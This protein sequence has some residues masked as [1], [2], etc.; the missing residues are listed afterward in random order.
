MKR[1]R[2]RD[3]V[4]LPWLV[5]PCLL[6]AGLLAWQ[7]FVT[8][9]NV[10]PFILPPPRPVLAEWVLLLSSARAWSHTAMTFAGA[11]SGFL[12]A[13]VLGVAAGILLS[14]SPTLERL[15]KPFIVAF[16]V[17]PKVALIPLFVVWMGFGLG[18]KILT[19]AILPFYPIMMNTL[20]GIRSVPEGLRDVMASF[21]AGRFQVL[22]RLELPYALPF[23]A[24]GLEVGI[25]LA[26]VGA[27][28]AEFI[29]G[30]SG[31]GYLLVSRIN[32][33]E[34]AQMFAIVLQ[35]CLLGL[36]LYAGVAGLRRLLVPRRA[37]PRPE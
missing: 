25:V 8:I 28:V 21:D 29:S 12:L 6:A 15:S 32:S 5:T 27:V 17:L 35:L 10:S 30:S 23:I 34:T 1:V 4:W 37:P 16:Q 3:A 9:W 24:T 7:G 14:L 31:L 19:S 13:T 2:L 36:V 22:R 20:L 11:V 33:Y 26:L 18:P